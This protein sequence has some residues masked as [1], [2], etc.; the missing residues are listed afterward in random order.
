MACLED[1]RLAPTLPM[2]SA[3][4]RGMLRRLEVSEEDV[5]QKWLRTKGIWPGTGSG[6]ESAESLH[7]VRQRQLAALG[8]KGNVVSSLKTLQALYRDKWSLLSLA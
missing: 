1:I 3:L 8:G 7:S 5:V 2:F 6:N 4:W